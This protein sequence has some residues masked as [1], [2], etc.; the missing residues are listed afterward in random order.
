MTCKIIFTVPFYHAYGAQPLYLL[1][2]YTA[3]L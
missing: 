1:G 2:C 3:G